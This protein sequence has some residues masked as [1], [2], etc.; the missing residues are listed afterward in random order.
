VGTRIYIYVLVSE[1]RVDSPHARFTGFMMGN[2]RQTLSSHRLLEA[3]SACN[4]YKYELKKHSG[5]YQPSHVKFPHR[6]HVRAV[7][8]QSAHQ[9]RSL[10]WQSMWVYFSSSEAVYDSLKVLELRL[11]CDRAMRG[12][13]WT[14]IV[15]TRHHRCSSSKF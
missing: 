15:L 10:A 7:H 3:P 2:M 13:H 14:S 11:K 5:A 4:M 1:E 12:V 6:E 8:H 9:D